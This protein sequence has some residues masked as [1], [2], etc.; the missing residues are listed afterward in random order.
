[1]NYLL[2]TTS[3]LALAGMFV[4]GG[5]LV[6]VLCL[7]VT[8]K[9]LPWFHYRD[10]TELGEIFADAIGGIFALLF[11]LV[12]VAVWQNHDRLDTT[13]SNEANTLHGLYRNLD[14]YPPAMRKHNEDLLKGYA[15]RVAKVEWELMKQGKQDPI[16]HQM[17]TQFNK[18][19]FAYRPAS[20]GEVPLH[21]QTLEL[22][23][24]YRGLRHDRLE[25]SESYL[26]NTMWC[27]L[28]LGAGI[29]IGYSCFFHTENQKAYRVMVAS[30][31]AALGLVFYML[32][33]YDNAFVGPGRVSPKAFQ[34]LGE[35]YWVLE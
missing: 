8:Q 27:A 6:S 34:D 22:I 24:R 28:V 23:S 30:L 3:P 12:T 9:A 33:I 4:C 17:I 16:S 10:T 15:D 25:G 2:T 26:D 5:A 35:K 31:G 14:S 20:I 11:A 29:Y 21:S 13:V 19:M 18:S 1:M 7:W 32:V